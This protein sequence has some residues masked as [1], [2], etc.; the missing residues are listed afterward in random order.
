MEIFSYIF[1]YF[2]ST[3]GV[4]TI[5]DFLTYSA[6]FLAVYVAY[7]A[8]QTWRK[9][10]IGKKKI[11]LACDIVEQVCNVQDII[12]DLRNP[13]CYEENKIKEDLNDKKKEV[14]DNKIYYLAAS[15]RFY[16]NNIDEINNFLKLRNKAQLYWNKDILLLFVEIKEIINSIVNAS[17]L[18]Y[19]TDNLNFKSRL[20]FE[21]KIWWCST[22]DKIEKKVQ[23][24][25][26][27]FKLNLKDFYEYKLTKWKK[28]K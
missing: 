11:D 17:E 14:K 7:M 28:L 22:D 26:D 4:N 1:N 15:Y 2:L 9:E 13:L 3:E 5:K 20:E 16:N 19:Y 27:E 6:P 8:L 24:I 25:V 18:L 23:Q 12:R 21:K 10:F